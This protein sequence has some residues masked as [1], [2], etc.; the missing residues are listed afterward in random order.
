MNVNLHIERLVLEGLRLRPGEHLLVRAA[1]ERELARLL[2]AGGVG[3]SL[4]SGGA[5]PRLSAGE[6]NLSG[7]GDARQ[8]GHQIAHAVYGGLNR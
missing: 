3:Q 4:M 5:A 2:A 7:E 6:I 8:L 1:A